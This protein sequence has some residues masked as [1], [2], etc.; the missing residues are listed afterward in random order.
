MEIDKSLS[1][2]ETI[3]RAQGAVPAHAG[4]HRRKMDVLVGGLRTGSEGTRL[5]H[6]RRR[7]SAPRGRRRSA[8]PGAPGRCRAPRRRRREARRARCAGPSRRAVRLRHTGQS[9]MPASTRRYCSGCDSDVA[10]SERPFV[11]TSA[12]SSSCGGASP[13]GSL[14]TRPAHEG[15]RS[16]EG[17]LDLGRLGRGHIQQPGIVQI[18]EEQVKDVLA[19]R[20]AADVP[21]QEIGDGVQQLVA[22]S[23]EAGQRTDG[24]EQPGTEPKRIRVLGGRRFPGDR[25]LHA[26]S[27]RRPSAR[28]PARTD[29]PRPPRRAGASAAARRPP[30]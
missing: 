4:L 15:Q 6:G 12:S 30:G 14:A 17:D 11:V 25:S 5:G 28:G 26:R 27:W 1:A 23:V 3:R 20:R 10:T 22:E 21:A 19:G 2:L 9:A 13:P 16:F 24:A 18:G 8:S 29:P 7:S